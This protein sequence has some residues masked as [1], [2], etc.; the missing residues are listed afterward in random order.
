MTHLLVTTEWLAAH[1]TDPNIRVI[2]IRGKVMPPTAPE[3]HYIS[4]REDY[5]RSHIPGAQFVVW[6]R[7]I[8]DPDS[9]YH[10]QIA[11]PERFAAKMSALGIDAETFVVAYDDAGSFLAARLWWA[12][13]Y[14]GHEK[15]AVVDGGWGKWVAE[16]HPVTDAVPTTEP[17]QFIAQPRP[18]IYR[19]GADVLASLSDPHIHLVDMRTKGEFEGQAARAKRKGHIPGASNQPRA[20]LLTANGE[21][22]PPDQLRAKFAAAGV[23]EN[24]PQ[25][26]FYCNSGASASFGLLAMRVAGIKSPAAVYDASWREWGNDDTTPVE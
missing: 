6:N 22:L 7:D 24:T 23:D 17:A 21:L 20:E 8:T 2:D 5:D 18:D 12:L 14:Y 1:L 10:A 9:F 13:N 15:V 25:V 19:S 11:K 16:N 3:P 4:H 26:V